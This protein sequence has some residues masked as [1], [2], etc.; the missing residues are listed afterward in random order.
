MV[1]VTGKTPSV[2]SAAARGTVWINRDA[3]NLIQGRNVDAKAKV[4]GDVLS[5]AQLAGITGAK[6]TSSL[7]PLCHPINLTHVD[8]QLKIVNPSSSPH[9]ADSDERPKIEITA[10]ATCVGSTGVEMEALTAV[11]VAALTVWDMLK[12]VAGREMEIGE[13]RVVGKSGGKSGDWQ[14]E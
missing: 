13:V 1:S 4:K 12:S 9:P 6:Q 8:V 3:L 7:I 11:N 5:V 2:R 10:T 14:R